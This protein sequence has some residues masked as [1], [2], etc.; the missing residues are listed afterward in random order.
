V[1]P[2]ALGALLGALN[3]ALIAMG[4]ASL[5]DVYNRHVEDAVLSAGIVP[6]VGLGALLG[7]LAGTVSTRSIWFRRF[8]LTL[9]ALLL[10]ALLGGAYYVGLDMIAL[11]AIPTA[12]AA[13]VLERAT[14]KVEPPPLPTAHAR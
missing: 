7:W 2:V 11:C 12:V 9:P 8:L 3:V 6:G 14:R 13:L 10:V 5:F 4:L 1:T